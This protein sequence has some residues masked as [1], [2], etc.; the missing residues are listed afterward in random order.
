MLLLCSL[1]GASDEWHQYYIAGRTVDFADWLADTAGAAGAV[2]L[3]FN[4][5]HAG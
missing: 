3:I 4:K 2:L 5:T 1:Y